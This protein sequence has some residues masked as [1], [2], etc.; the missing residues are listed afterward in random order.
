MNAVVDFRMRVGN[1]AD[2]ARLQAEGEWLKPLIE[3]LKEMG[4]NHS[5]KRRVV[6]RKW[7]TRW[8]VCMKTRPK[9]WDDYLFEGL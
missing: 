3:E 5:E 1:P 9:D 2:W 4:S 7:E 8:V 6:M